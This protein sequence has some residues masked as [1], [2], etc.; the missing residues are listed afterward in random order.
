MTYPI[1][2]KLPNQKAYYKI[3]SSHHFEEIQLLGK[4]IFHYTIE[5]NQYPEMLK[6]KEMIGLV[7]PY[8]I[9]NEEEYQFLINLKEN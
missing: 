5:A 8:Q 4:K 9:S 3:N 1:Y 2:R 7:E 6:I